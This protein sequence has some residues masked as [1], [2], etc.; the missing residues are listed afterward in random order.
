MSFTL[1]V[2]DDNMDLTDK[3]KEELINKAIRKLE[4]DEVNLYS[5]KEIVQVLFHKICRNYKNLQI[6]EI[7]DINEEYDGETQTIELIKNYLQECLKNYK[8]DE[9]L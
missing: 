3:E 8:E 5:T 9:F 1:I 6:N 2:G 4:R 7:K